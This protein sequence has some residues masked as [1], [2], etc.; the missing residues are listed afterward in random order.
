MT[1]IWTPL[2]ALF[3]L[4]ACDDRTVEHVDVDQAARETA[5][6]VQQ[7]RETSEA[8]LEAVETYVD[9]SATALEDAG[10]AEDAETLD[11]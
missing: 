3:I 5:D 6:R 7:V 11:R 2:L 4:A 10:V 8:R 9:R 1:K